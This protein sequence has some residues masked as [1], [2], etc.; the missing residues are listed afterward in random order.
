MKVK[1]L[2]GTRTWA[3]ILIDPAPYRSA[4]RERTIP[5]YEAGGLRHPLELLVNW[6][7]LT[8]LPLPIP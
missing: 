3:P 4:P 2:R 1:S 6:I 5:L 7:R 8:D